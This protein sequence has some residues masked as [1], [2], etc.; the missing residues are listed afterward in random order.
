TGR[1]RQYFQFVGSLNLQRSGVYR[2]SAQLGGIFDVFDQ[3]IHI[4]AVE[5]LRQVGGVV[6]AIHKDL[7]VQYALQQRNVG[8][9]AGNTHALQIFTQFGDGVVTIFAV[10]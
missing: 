3:S 1:W 5:E 8:A 6:Y 2:V 9:H 4:N 7:V 10:A